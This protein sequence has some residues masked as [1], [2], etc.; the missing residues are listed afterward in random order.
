MICLPNTT[1]GLIKYF[2]KFIYLA[3]PISTTTL[4]ST[5]YFIFIFNVFLPVLCPPTR[6]FLYVLELMAYI[7]YLQTNV[8]EIV[9]VSIG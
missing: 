1:Y 8:F 3:Y 4:K 2:L 7:N 5:F 6:S 9:V